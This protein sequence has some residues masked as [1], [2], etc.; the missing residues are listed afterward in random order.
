MW[1]AAAGTACARAAPITCTACTLPTAKVAAAVSTLSRGS[2]GSLAARR[3][4]ELGGQFTLGQR[5]TP[6]TFTRSVA[7]TPHY[8]GARDGT[9]V[10]SVYPAAR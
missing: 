8:R 2:R 1:T 5:S 10:I 6:L 3:C 9:V 4:P 7:P